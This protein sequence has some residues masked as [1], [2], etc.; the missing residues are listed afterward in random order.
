M[1]GASNVQTHPMDFEK[2]LVSNFAHRSRALGEDQALG[3]LYLENPQKPLTS[4]PKLFVH[5]RLA[6]IRVP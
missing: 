1:K 3:G 5:G 4:T 6:A 2:I